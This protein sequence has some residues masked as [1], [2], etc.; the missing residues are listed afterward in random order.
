MN[1]HL[2]D[3]EVACHSYVT[4]PLLLNAEMPEMCRLHVTAPLPV[5]SV[6][7]GA[8]VLMYSQSRL[9]GYQEGSFDFVTEQVT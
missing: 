4:S 9:A 6:C 7:Y 2:G 5:D 8:H 1:R 3:Q